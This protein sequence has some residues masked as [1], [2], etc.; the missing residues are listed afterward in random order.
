MLVDTHGINH[1]AY[2]HQDVVPFG[3]WFASVVCL[4]LNDANGL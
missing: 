1:V 4:S 2:F 3:V